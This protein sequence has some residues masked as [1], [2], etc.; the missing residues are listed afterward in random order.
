M[1]KRP[2]ITIKFSAT[3]ITIQHKDAIYDATPAN[4]Q[5]LT[6]VAANI[7]NIVGIK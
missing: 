2:T 3:G 5:E 6:L 7:C 4:N 1:A